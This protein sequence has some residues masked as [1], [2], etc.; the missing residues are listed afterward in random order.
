VNT[1]GIFGKE[2]NDMQILNYYF[3]DPKPLD[4]TNWNNVGAVYVILDNLLRVIDVGQASGLNDRLVS[5][6]RR[7]C[8]E[9]NCGNQGIFVAAL[10]VSS[11]AGRLEIENAIRSSYNPICGIQ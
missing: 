9:R 4:G 7:G 8:W 6:D 3:E 5:H 11:E 1:I 10:A 2:V